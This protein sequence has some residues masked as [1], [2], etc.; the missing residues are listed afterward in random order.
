MRCIAKVVALL[1]VSGL[2]FCVPGVAAAASEL[3]HTYTEAEDS[4]DSPDAIYVMNDVK[5]SS[6]QA[7]VHVHWEQGIDKGDQEFVVTLGPGQSQF[8]ACRY[9]SYDL[10]PTLYRTAWVVGAAEV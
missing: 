1:A 10:S 2:F 9:D 4:C 7:T 6:V 8:L 3:A 5:D